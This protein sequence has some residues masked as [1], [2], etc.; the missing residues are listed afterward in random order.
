MNKVDPANPTNP[1]SPLQPTSLADPL[2][3]ETGTPGAG[4]DTGASLPIGA[5]PARAVK[6]DGT[7]AGEQLIAMVDDVAPSAKQEPAEAGE[8]IGLPKG[9]RS[10]TDARQPIVGRDDRAHHLAL[11]AAPGVPV[12]LPFPVPKPAVLPSVAKPS[13]AAAVKSRQRAKPEGRCGLN[14]FCDPTSEAG[15]GG[16]YCDRRFNKV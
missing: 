2:P 13:N 6:V 10:R 15:C 14:G 5:T 7:S 1:I 9:E 12:S 8:A 3:A 11:V 16:L 4:G